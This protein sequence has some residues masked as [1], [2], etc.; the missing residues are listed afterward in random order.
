MGGQ[1]GVMVSRAGHGRWKEQW[2][3]TGQGVEVRAEQMNKLEMQQ[4][5]F[6]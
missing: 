1:E 6:L 4:Y 5:I 3:S 2:V